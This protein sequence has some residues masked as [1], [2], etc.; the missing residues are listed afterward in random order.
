MSPGQAADGTRNGRLGARNT[1]GRRPSSTNFDLERQLLKFKL[2]IATC[3]DSA[4]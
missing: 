1:R 2:R 4:T 3:E